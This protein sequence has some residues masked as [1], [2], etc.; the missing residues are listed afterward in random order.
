MKPKFGFLDN[1]PV[2]YLV[3]EGWIFWRGEWHPVHPAEIYHDG[4]VLTEEQFN[5]L[6]P[7]LPSLPSTAFQSTESDTP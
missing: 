6:Y 3:T 4:R 2:R 5:E 1:Q 7:D